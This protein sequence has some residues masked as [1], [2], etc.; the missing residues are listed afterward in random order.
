[1][2]HGTANCENWNEHLVHILPLNNKIAFWK[3]ENYH[4]HTKRKVNKHDIREYLNQNFGIAVRVFRINKHKVILTWHQTHPTNVKIKNLE[5]GESIISKI[6]KTLK[7]KS[8]PFSWAPKTGTSLS[9]FPHSIPSTT[10][11]REN[12]KSLLSNN[13]FNHRKINEKKPE[14]L[15]LATLER[16]IWRLFWFNSDLKSLASTITSQFPDKNW[17]ERHKTILKIYTQT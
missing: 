14:I 5:Q 4:T 9:V 13:S 17:T 10:V 12:P 15:I 1:M 2:S 8:S 3:L 16:D 11:T 6:C 7:E